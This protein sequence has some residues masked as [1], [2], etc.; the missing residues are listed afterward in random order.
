MLVEVEK[1]EFAGSCRWK[2]ECSEKD[3]FGVNCGYSKMY[4]IYIF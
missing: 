2:F 3:Q 1:D 4:F